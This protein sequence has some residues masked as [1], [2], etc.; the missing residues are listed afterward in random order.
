M[1]DDLHLFLDEPLPRRRHEARRAAEIILV[2]FVSLVPTGIDYDHVARTHRGAGGL[3]QIVVRDRFPLLLRNGHHDA[4]AEEVWQR[5][6]IDEGSALDDMRGRINMRRIV[7]ARRDALGQH[8]GLGV[9]MD[10]LD[11]DIF[12][13]GPIRG[14]IAETMR[15]VVELEPHA[16]GEVL[17]ERHAA[18]L[19]CHATPPLAALRV[20]V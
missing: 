12:E 14:L 6:L 18:N 19:F 20:R 3:F 15:E 10:A 4:R 5:N 13:V 11:L 7:H 8:A 17:L 9:V 16:V 2:V 1:A